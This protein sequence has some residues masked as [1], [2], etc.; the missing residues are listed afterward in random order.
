MSMTEEE[1]GFVIEGLVYLKLQAER[2]FSE[3][4]RL[5][6]KETRDHIC[7]YQSK[8]LRSLQTLIDKIKN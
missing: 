8:K 3:F 4:K 7:N 6:D 2:E 5:K 1:S